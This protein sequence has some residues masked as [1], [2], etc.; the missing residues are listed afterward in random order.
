MGVLL[1]AGGAAL[2]VRERSQKQLALDHTL[3]SRVDEDASRIEAYFDRARSIAL[4]N[5]HNP[6]FQDFYRLSG[7]LRV[8]G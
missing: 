8:A 6:A 2:G 1:I 5:A 4:I 3:T 7:L